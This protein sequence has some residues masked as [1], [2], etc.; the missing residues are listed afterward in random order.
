MTITADTHSQENTNSDWSMFWAR[1]ISIVVVCAFGLASLVSAIGNSQSYPVNARI[2]RVQMLLGNYY[3]SFQKFPPAAVIHDGMKLYSWRVLIADSEGCHALGGIP[4]CAW[5]DPS[6]E[7]LRRDAGYFGY[8]PHW[9]ASYAGDTMLLAVVGPGTAWNIEA[10]EQLANSYDAI[11]LIEH[12]DSGINWTQPE[13]VDIESLA[14]VVDRVKTLAKDSRSRPFFAVM[15]ADTEIWYLSP[16]VPTAD[17]MQ[18]ATLAGAEQYDRDKV[19]GPYRI[20]E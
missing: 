11:L 16:N 13:D 1:A 19:L 5:N 4:E 6:L 10:E 15:F 17:L 2:R 14:T 9:W 12:P 20:Q 8:P 18:F 7:A 3:L